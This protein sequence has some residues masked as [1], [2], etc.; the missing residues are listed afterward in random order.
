MAGHAGHV[1]YRPTP[2]P[3]HMWDRESGK[4]D[5]RP[6]IH[7]KDLIDRLRVDC[8][9]RSDGH[10]RCVVYQ[11]VDSAKCRSCSFHKRVDLRCVSQIDRYGKNLCTGFLNELLCS[12][13]FGYVEVA[14][15]QS[16]S[17]PR[18]SQSNAAT[19]SVTCSRNDCDFIF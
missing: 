18:K 17:F 9:S 8:F 19:D 3:A 2:G 11:T 10:H 4:Q 7:L 16:G 12:A 1:D 13:E 6:E 5:R 15:C 14:D